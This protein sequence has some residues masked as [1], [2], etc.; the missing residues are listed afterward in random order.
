[1]VLKTS[2]CSKP[3][4]SSFRELVYGFAVSPLELDADNG[5]DG[6]ADELPVA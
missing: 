6:G 1:M 3:K 4:E 5:G 2:P